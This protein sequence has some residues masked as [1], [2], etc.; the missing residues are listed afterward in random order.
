MHKDLD[1][2]FKLVFQLSASI[3]QSCKPRRIVLPSLVHKKNASPYGTYIYK[4]R[5]KLVHLKCTNAPPTSM[6]K[7]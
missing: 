3:F 4:K 5:I 1:K 7:I 2:S 6:K